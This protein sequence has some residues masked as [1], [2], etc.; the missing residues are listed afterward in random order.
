[1]TKGTSVTLTNISIL[2]WRK[3]GGMNTNVRYGG[4]YIKTLVPGGA[5]DQDGRIQ[6]G[7]LSFKCIICTDLTF[8]I[9]LTLTHAL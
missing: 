8:Q 7:N 4:I 2:S 9:L 1:M 3:K 5:A 6:I